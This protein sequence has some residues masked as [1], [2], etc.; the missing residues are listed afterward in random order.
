MRSYGQYRFDVTA[1]RLLHLRGR[2]LTDLIESRTVY[3]YIC[4]FNKYIYI[5]MDV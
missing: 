5:Y 3:I 1:G 2:S 4:M